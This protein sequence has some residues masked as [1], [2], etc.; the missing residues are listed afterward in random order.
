MSQILERLANANDKGRLLEN[1]MLPTI[2]SL[3]FLNVK[4]QNS[5]SQY[6]F[7]L[8]GYKNILVRQECWKF[9]CKNLTGAAS[10]SDLAPKL[11]W[12]VNNPYLDR[13]VIIALNG[14]NNDLRYY[15]E[16]NPYSFTIEIWSGQYLEKLI[17]N[18]PNALMQL[19]LQ[20]TNL[21]VNP[22]AQPEIFEAS[23]IKFEV[24][25]SG[26]AFSQDYFLKNEVL[27]KAFTEMDF[28]LTSVIYNETNKDIIIQELNVKTISYNRTV[29]QRVLRQTT[30]R[31]IK[32]P[33][34]LTFT[35]STLVS[36]RYN[37]IE[38]KILDVKK[39]SK[40]YLDLRLSRKCLPG[41]YE[42]IVELN[43][44][45][46]SRKFSLYSQIFC[47][48]KSGYGDDL[49]ELC[50]LGDFYDSP[51]KD[52]LE[53]TGPIWAKMRKPYPQTIKHLGPTLNCT[54]KADTTWKVNL[55]KGKKVKSKGGYD[56]DVKNARKATEL[57][58]LNIPVTEKIVYAEDLMQEFI[59]KN[60]SK[61]D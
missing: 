48:H 28:K 3:G 51:A 54:R 12:H 61:N 20:D 33:L 38:G 43:C 14:I 36:G 25:Y 37:M 47:L 9:E 57:L 41:Y 35:P 39:Q 13:F 8:I 59:I 23:K 29:G 16:N 4:R 52:I 60:I 10:I 46:G 34:R 31:G 53:T 22:K 32:S 49:V 56:L 27:I 42:L 21:S 1:V 18:C 6:G 5:G 55:L 58:D 19:N 44:M 50:V 17:A 11:M 45:E 30:Q 40:E 26:L 7:D 24:A 15:L 2:E